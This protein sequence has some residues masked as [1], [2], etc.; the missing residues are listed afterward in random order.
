MPATLR[1]IATFAVAAFNERR[2]LPCDGMDDQIDPADQTSHAEMA[3]TPSPSPSGQR[4]TTPSNPDMST[5]D[6]FSYFLGCTDI[7]F[8]LRTDLARHY[9]VY[10]REPA[11]GRTTKSK[12]S[13]KTLEARAVAALSFFRTLHALGMT[14]KQIKNVKQ[15][16]VEAAVLNYIQQGV[17]VGTIENRLAHLSSLMTQRNHR[18]VVHPLRHY[19]GPR[20]VLRGIEAVERRLHDGSLRRSTIAREDKTWSGKGIDILATIEE[21]ERSGEDRIAATLRLC[22]AL[23]TRVEE[24]MLLRPVSELMKAI[25]TATVDIDRG[26]KGGRPRQLQLRE[27]SQIHALSIAARIVEADGGN[28]DR[29]LIPEGTSLKQWKNHFYYVVRRA[30][31][32]RSGLGVTSHGLRHEYLNQLY[33]SLSGSASP[34][35]GG[36]APGLIH[37]A[38][39]QLVSEAA[40]HSRASKANAY[41]ST[42]HF[43]R[44]IRLR[45]DL[46][47][48]RRTVVAEG[49]DLMMSVADRERPF[50]EDSGSGDL[51]DRNAQE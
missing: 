17:A 1:P 9:K 16:H 40:G 32:R 43:A 31:I 47:A 46:E 24:A 19:V 2:S 45:E 28:S 23:G 35:K 8:E 6:P 18:D 30:G 34:I 10:G 14:V 38:A 50:I 44:L 7:P 49:S 13:F 22:W 25:E 20:G 37:H 3:R 33:F 5:F 27:A 36:Q 42:P 15:R 26:T 41:L 12:L 4:R 48:Q 39:L 11:R 51:I 29:T 21:I